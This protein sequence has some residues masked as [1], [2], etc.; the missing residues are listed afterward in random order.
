MRG[1]LGAVWQDIDADPAAF[2]VIVA[3]SATSIFGRW[4]VD[5]GANDPQLRTRNWKEARAIIY[6][7]LNCSKPILSA[8]KGSA[9]GAG[10]ARVLLAE[11]SMAAKEARFVDTRVANAAQMQSAGD[12][13][14]L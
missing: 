12:R 3:S 10:L 6:N 13:I 8:I 2:S 11:I 4:R 7:M 14:T 1:E 9:A 5:R